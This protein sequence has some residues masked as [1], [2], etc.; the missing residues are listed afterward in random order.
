MYSSSKTR[1]L[2]PVRHRNWLYRDSLNKVRSYLTIWI[3]SKRYNRLSELAWN[4]TNPTWSRNSN[5][6]MKTLYQKGSWHSSKTWRR[7]KVREHT[8]SRL[9][10]K[11]P[12]ILLSHIL[13]GLLIR[14]SPTRKVLILN[15]TQLFLTT[16]PLKNKEL[17]ISDSLQNIMMR[18]FSLR[19][20]LAPYQSIATEE[21]RTSLLTG[22]SMII[23]T[24]KANSGPTQMHCRCLKGIWTREPSSNSNRDNLEFHRIT[25]QWAQLL[26]LGIS[27]V[28]TSK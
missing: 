6:K 8:S 17:S 3:N 1:R 19:L 20:I 27:T 11:G 10:G 28:P 13:M 14:K 26:L 25:T 24:W 16:K 4:I 7:P 21:A 2:Q 15:N 5:S 9:S 18:S 23:L 12:R 22:N